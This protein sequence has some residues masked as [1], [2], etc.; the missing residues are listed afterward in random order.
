MN[1]N[2]SIALALGFVL[3]VLTWVYGNS[4][5]QS[6]QWSMVGENVGRIEQ[7]IEPKILTQTMWFGAIGTGLLIVSLKTKK[8]KK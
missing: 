4:Q 1:K 8:K 7:R 3:M 6:Y 5:F 2:Q